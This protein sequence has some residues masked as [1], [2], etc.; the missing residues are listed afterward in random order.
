M[1]Q[2]NI[3][4]NP[5][6]PG[7]TPDPVILRD[8][9]DYYIATSTFHWFPGIQIFHS[10]DLAHW[11]LKSYVVKDPDFL[12]L[13]GTET[14]AGIW[15]PDLSYDPNTGRYWI[16]MCQMHNMNGNLFDQDN[17][18]MWAN[19]IKG[20]WSKP[21]YLNSIGFDC[22]LFHDDDG[23]HWIVTLE[24]DTRKGYQHPGAVVLEEFDPAAEKL[25]G[26][27]KRITRGGTDRGCLE[28]PH[29]YKHNGWYY[30]MT[31]EGGT[32]YGHGVV[33]QRS[34]HIDGP[35]ESDPQNPII[36]STPYRFFRRND[37]DS[38]RIDL[39]NPKA[40]LQK[41][42]HGSLVHT[43]T[44]EWYIVHLSARPLP[45]TT[46][47]TLGRETSI[48][49]VEW[50]NDGWLRMKAGGTLAQP[51]TEAMS[52]VPLTEAPQAVGLNDDFNGKDIDIHLISPYGPRTN[53]WFSLT[54]RPGWAR[55]SGRQSF[56]SRFDVS[57]LAA[58]IESFKATVETS[59]EFHPVH[60]SQSAGLVLYYD[61]SNWLFARLYHSETLGTTALSIMKGEK[62]QKDEYVL[63]RVAISD[64]KAIIKAVIDYGTVQFYWHRPGE[65]D[66]DLLGERI[67]IQ[68]MSDEQAGGF[69][70]LMGGIGAWDA[71]RRQ[72]YADF[73][74]FKIIAEPVR[75]G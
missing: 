71:Y 41:C 29:L 51:F 26:P 14:P 63:D 6:L 35:Y 75:N 9:K 11:R 4:Q 32:G 19:S 30:L 12:Q 38:L 43:H 13:K 18:A 55:I 31:A 16:V 5:I 58:R 45:G 2:S 15:A 22:S 21:I 40:P 62:G 34:K 39:Y 17:Y 67:D 33:V 24:W 66:W 69:T 50:T 72:S 57:L 10:L 42:G 70:G 3:I 56:F 60:Y 68:Y 46:N 25:V 49:K 47:C 8:G 73:D 7:F 48:Q 20:P 74:Y 59:L 54:H 65:K 53:S 28:A 27:T 36:T 52:G 64:G 23:R 37:P 44:D 1:T 61:D